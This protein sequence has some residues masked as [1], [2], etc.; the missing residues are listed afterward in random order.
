MRIKKS[1]ISS[2]FQR[3][4]SD[5]ILTSAFGFFTLV[6]LFWNVASRWK[7]PSG[8]TFWNSEKNNYHNA[9]RVV[10]MAGP[11]GTNFFTVRDIISKWATSYKLGRW[12]WSLPYVITKS[13]EDNSNGSRGFHPLVDALIYQALS[14]VHDDQLQSL[15]IKNQSNEDQDQI[16]YFLEEYKAAFVAA[17]MKGNNIILGSETLSA[18]VKYKEDGSE[19]LN[20][21]LSLMPWEHEKFELD[22]SQDNIV[23]VV[24]YFDDRLAQLQ[25]TWKS[26][27]FSDWILQGKNDFSQIDSLA[28]AAKF[29]EKNFKVAIVDMEGVVKEKSDISSVVACQIMEVPCKRN[30]VLTLENYDIP[31]PLDLKPIESSNRKMDLTSDQ[32]KEIEN[33]LHEYDCHYK[34]LRVH[35]KVEI[36]FP[37]TLSK[38]LLSCPSTQLADQDVTTAEVELEQ[39]IYNIAKKAKKNI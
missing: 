39:K 35:E 9:Q 34:H 32:L 14:V 24:S 17:W 2:R 20:L 10:I 27:K 29:L 7:N 37:Y 38:R 30:R 6:V 23:V 16:D 5:G 21:L 12:E 19:V 11:Y 18:V 1:N 26:G 28:L 4:V 33:A 22:G 15:G 13:L 31:I 25:L 36:I 8:M 3:K